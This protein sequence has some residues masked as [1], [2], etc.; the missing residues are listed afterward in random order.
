MTGCQTAVLM[1]EP[2]KIESAC[3]FQM[4]SAF[5]YGK[6]RGHPKQGE[7]GKV[8]E[9]PP[10]SQDDRGWHLITERKRKGNALTMSDSV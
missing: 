9:K 4:T 1:T 10:G 8:G 6:M 7:W 2:L 5:N 3:V